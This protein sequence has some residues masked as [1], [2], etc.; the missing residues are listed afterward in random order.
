MQCKDVGKDGGKFRRCG[1]KKQK[2]KNNFK[3]NMREPNRGL[4][5]LTESK[6]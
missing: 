2:A 5:T 6:T 3:S 4:L 1:S